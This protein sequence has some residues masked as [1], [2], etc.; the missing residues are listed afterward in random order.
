V[1]GPRAAAR[2]AI[3]AALAT[4]AILFAAPSLTYPLSR[5]QGIFYYV[6]REWLRHGTMPYRDAVDNKTPFIYA[7]NALC[8]AVFGDTM[9]GIR[10]ADLLAVAVLGALVARLSVEPG[11][12]AER[13]AY[14]ASMLVASVFYYGYLPFQ[15]SANCE[16]WC[17]LFVVAAVVVVRE[18]R[19]DSLAALVAGALLG[20]AFLAKPPSMAFAPLVAHAWIARRRRFAPAALATLGFASVVGI[21][22]AYFAAR[23][24]LDALVDL[25][26]HANAAFVAHGRRVRSLADVVHFFGVA[27]DWYEPWSYAFIGIVTIAVVRARVGRDRALAVRYLAPLAWAACAYAAAAVQLKLF[28]YHHSLFIVPCALLGATLWTD[29]AAM[30]R[31]RTRTVRAA[32]AVAFVAAVVVSCVANTPRDVWRLRALNAVR[33]ALGRLDAQ[34][35]VG[36]F[37]DPHWIDLTDVQKAGL[38]VRDHSS[39]EDALLV[40]GYEPEMYFFAQRRYGGRFFWSAMLVLPELDYRRAEWLLQDRAEIDTIRPAWVVAKRNAPERDSVQW[41]ETMGYVARA[42]LG[43]FVVMSR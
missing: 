13:G 14:G 10:L 3:D 37:D 19:G 30:T 31:T 1:I 40:R 42:E 17:A 32:A 22:V 11:E 24:A 41:F 5:D 8:I 34:T 18:L 27:L 12:R 26:V 28:V 33:F 23:H 43:P 9:W 16:I 2:V 25:T 7:I 39:P 36:T 38:F 21:V 35:L 4:V 20:V 6:G 29:L 15:D